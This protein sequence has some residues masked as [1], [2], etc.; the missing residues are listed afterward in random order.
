MR[1]DYLSEVVAIGSPPLIL[2]VGEDGENAG[3]LEGLAVLLDKLGERLTFKRT[4]TRVLYQ[5]I[6]AENRGAQ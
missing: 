4:R 5:A 3:P 1:A 6:L 2:E